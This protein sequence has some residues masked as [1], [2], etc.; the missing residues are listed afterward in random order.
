MCSGQAELWDW[1][2]SILKA[3][4]RAGCPCHSAG[5]GWAARRL[6]GQPSM[7]PLPAL[8]LCTARRP[9]PRDHAP[10]LLLRPGQAEVWHHALG[11]PAWGQH[12][13]HHALSQPDP[14]KALR[15]TPAHGCICT[16]PGPCMRPPQGSRGG[17]M[18]PGTNGCF[19]GVSL[20]SAVCVCTV[21]VTM[22][23][24]RVWTL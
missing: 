14:G 10:A 20:L 21:L 19:R 17:C 13:C 24:L 3:Q 12:R 22:A 5:L 15:A 6:A 23:A 7:T 18:L 11:A 4:V 8:S 9:A 2:T 1:T 16:H